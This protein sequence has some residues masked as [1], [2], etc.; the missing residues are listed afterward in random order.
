MGA[1]V[2]FKQAIQRGI[3]V[4]FAAVPEQAIDGFG[5]LSL[6][7]AVFQLAAGLGKAGGQSLQFCCF[8]REA[9]ARAE[10]GS[11]HGIPSEAK[12]QFYQPARSGVSTHRQSPV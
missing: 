2:G 11:F 4:I 7:V 9:V 8:P 3:D 1:R 6:P 10:T 5:E 12:K